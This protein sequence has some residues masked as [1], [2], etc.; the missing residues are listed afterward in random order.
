MPQAR[1]GKGAEVALAAVSV[2]MVAFGAYYLRPQ[3]PLDV[4]PVNQRTVPAPVDLY[5]PTAGDRL[6]GV[7]PSWGR[8]R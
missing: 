7:P 4:S 8:T 2:G 1:F 6:T 5:Q 3:K